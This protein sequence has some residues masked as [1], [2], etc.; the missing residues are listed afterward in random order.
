MKVNLVIAR[1]VEIGLLEGVSRWKSK[2]R[3]SYK[4]MEVEAPSV[5]IGNGICHC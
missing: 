3:G 4:A 2:S 1:G 5:L